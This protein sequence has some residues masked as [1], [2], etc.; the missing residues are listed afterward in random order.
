MFSKKNNIIMIIAIGI[1]LIFIVGLLF[2]KNL[3]MMILPQTNIQTNETSETSL[4]TGKEATKNLIE[5]TKKLANGTDKDKI[6]KVITI[7]HAGSSSSEE[8][9]V[10]AP[11]SNPIS[12]ATGGVMTRNGS[13]AAKN[14][15]RPGDTDAPLQSA[16]VDV[17]KLPAS[18]IKLTIGS[19]SISPAEFTVSAGQAVSLAVTTGNS[20]E[21]FKFDDPVLKAVVIGLEPQ[22]T[23]VITFNAPTKLGEYVFYS[24]FAGHRNSGVTG[25]MIVK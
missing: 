23:R 17:N 15:T 18:T 4:E 19:S 20:I 16:P 21:I 3:S 22:Q 9:I 5:E 25:K 2:W 24:D 14:D 1:L 13:E 7:D 12:V 11:Q 10:V 8:M 6:A